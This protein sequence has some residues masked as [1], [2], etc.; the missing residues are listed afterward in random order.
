MAICIAEGAR[1]R[2]TAMC[3]L[4]G[5]TFFFEKRAQAFDHPAK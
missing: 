2:F 5:V 3:V 4:N 1:K